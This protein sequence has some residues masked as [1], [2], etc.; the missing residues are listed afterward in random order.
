MLALFWPP[1]A[2]FVEQMSIWVE[3]AT[4][5][6]VLFLTLA[7]WVLGL[8]LYLLWQIIRRPP[9]VIDIGLSQS[10]DAMELTVPLPAGKTKQDV[11]CAILPSSL[12]LSIRGVRPSPYLS[13]TFLRPVC[14]DDS[15]WQM[16]PVGARPPAR[17]PA[18][19]GNGASTGE[20][21]GSGARALGPRARRNAAAAATQVAMARKASRSL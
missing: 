15:Y 6:P 3:V 5:W 7:C 8:S 20:A 17:R 13:G 18:H 2:V 12:M 14:V 4:Q 16:W 9:A 19:V 10:V 1:L 21:V 11:Q